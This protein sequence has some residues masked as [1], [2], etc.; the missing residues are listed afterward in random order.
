[1]PKHKAECIFR[2]THCEKCGKKII[3]NELRIHAPVCP[4]E[5]IDCT[6]ACGSKIIR[7][8]AKEHLESECLNRL[9]CCD[10]ADLGCTAPI[11]KKDFDAHFSEAIELHT[12]NVLEFIK[13][14][15]KNIDCA[16]D[17]LDNYCVAVDVKK[18]CYD[19]IMEKVKLNYE[20]YAK[21]LEEEKIKKEKN[22]NNKNYLIANEE[23]NINKILE[24]NLT[25]SKN[26][27][28]LNI[29]ST[30]Q[31]SLKETININININKS[32][33]NKNILNYESKQENTS[34]NLNALLEEDNNNQSV[35]NSKALNDSGNKANKNKEEET[36]DKNLLLG[37][38]TKSAN[39][40]KLAAAAAEKRLSDYEKFFEENKIMKASD[41]KKI[42]QQKLSE[43]EESVIQQYQKEISNIIE[44]SRSDGK[45]R[46]EILNSKNEEKRLK[47]DEN[48]KDHDLDLNSDQPSRN[49]SAFKNIKKGSS[50]RQSTKNLIQ[51]STEKAK[52][53]AAKAISSNS[54]Y[55]GNNNKKS[56]SS[57][58]NKNNSSEKNNNKNNNINSLRNNFYNSR[59]KPN[60]LDIHNASFNR[61]G[62]AAK[63]PTNL[64]TSSTTLKQ[65]FSG[66]SGDTPQSSKTSENE[67]DPIK[68]LKTASKVFV[69]S[70]QLAFEHNVITTSDFNNRDHLFFLIEDKAFCENSKIKLKI[71]AAP[72]SFAFGFCIK[73]LI[74]DGGLVFNETLVNHGFFVISSDAYL[75]HSNSS[76]MNN[77]KLRNFPALKQNDEIL[78]QY[79]SQR[80]EMVVRI[81][82]KLDF[83]INKIFKLHNSQTILPCIIFQ[84]KGE[85]IKLEYLQS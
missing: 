69:Y 62:A 24:A 56:S 71:L 27:N 15:F 34:K 16:L 43:I 72:H 45:K 57:D 36:K 75:F 35:K 39:K 7:N 53:A 61:T 9:V 18:K 25:S 12:K 22:E 31:S 55:N 73:E 26:L 8:S 40:A 66:N 4:K 82:N 58:S 2:E 41:I 23:E 80:D 33:N 59:S 11:K 13:R 67:E 20:F 10:F 51:E 49:S 76:F 83:K 47:A 44:N 21:Q 38:K 81:N 68:D 63:N 78:I 54:N 19:E 70:K 6:N 60:L 64:N 77:I 17:G 50:V 37:K 1:M 85:K 5:E 48:A 29:N 46:R 14:M 74:Y 28:S 42:K 32:N 84:N 65:K 52:G 3:F 79:F 30:I